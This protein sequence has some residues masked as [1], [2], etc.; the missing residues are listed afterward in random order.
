M[1]RRDWAEA[2]SLLQ[3]APRP[4]TH[5]RREGEGEGVEVEVGGATESVVEVELEKAAIVC[6]LSCL[7]ADSNWRKRY[8]VQL[9]VAVS[10]CCEFELMPA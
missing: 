1:R 6:E 3:A 7:M 5:W 4:R 10:N 8:A 2:A 9:I